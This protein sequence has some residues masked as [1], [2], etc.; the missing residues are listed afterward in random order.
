MGRTLGLCVTPCI[1]WVDE[2]EKAFSGVSNDDN[3]TLRRMFG[4]FLTWMQDKQSAVYVIAT[5]NNAENLPPELK[6][7]GRFDEI[8]CV[9]LPDNSERQEIFKVHLN[10]KK[11]KREIWEKINIDILASEMSGLSEGCNGADIESIINESVEEWFLN[12]SS[13][14]FSEILRN[15]TMNV[16]SISKSCK[17]QIDGMKSAFKKGSFVN[18]SL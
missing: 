4:F 7:K 16:I 12:G 5:A 2:I 18:A 11:G 17:E 10:K 9:N 6:R 1:L 15:H 8:F 14:D 3:G 13:S